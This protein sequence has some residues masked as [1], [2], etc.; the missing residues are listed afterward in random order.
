MVDKDGWILASLFTSIFTFLKTLTLSAKKECDLHPAI[1]TWHSLNS[2]YIIWSN[3][4]GKIIPEKGC[5]WDSD[6]LSVVPLKLSN[7]SYYTKFN[8]PHQGYSHPGNKTGLLYLAML[9]RCPCH[10]WSFSLSFC[11]LFWLFLYGEV[12][13]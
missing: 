9:L 12:K 8:I 11:Y 1:L 10:F 4:P 5:C 13:K 7:V 3:S 6:V 2:K